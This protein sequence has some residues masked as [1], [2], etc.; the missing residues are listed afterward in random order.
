MDAP[1]STSDVG[2]LTEPEGTVMHN[3]ASD[4]HGVHVS[5]LPWVSGAV[6][7]VLAG[8]GVTYLPRMRARSAQVGI[9]WSTARSAMDSAAISRDAA[10]HEVPAAGELFARAELLAASRGG[11][12]AA[13]E[14]ADC[15]QRADR[16]WREAAGE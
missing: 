15:A 6:L 12:A 9:A 4:R 8:F 16:L 2:A 5:W 7:L 11:A 14:A 1:L 3:R 13:E 10:P